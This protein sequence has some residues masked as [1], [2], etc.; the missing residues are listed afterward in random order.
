MTH[1]KLPE[2]KYPENA[3][4]CKL[5]GLTVTCKPSCDPALSTDNNPLPKSGYD[6]YAPLVVSSPGEAQKDD[7]RPFLHH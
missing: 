2:G 7:P 3:E 6:G 5:N 1:D 4:I